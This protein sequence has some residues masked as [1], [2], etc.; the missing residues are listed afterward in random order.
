MLRWSGL[1]TLT[2]TEYAL[3]VVNYLSTR[4][5]YSPAAFKFFVRPKNTLNNSKT[6]QMLSGKKEECNEREDKRWRGRSSYVSTLNYFCK[7]S[8]SSRHGA[9]FSTFFVIF[10]LSMTAAIPDQCTAATQYTDWFL[11]RYH[12]YWPSQL[13]FSPVDNSSIYLVVEPVQQSQHI[14]CLNALWSRQ[15]VRNSSRV[16][17]ILRLTR[18]YQYVVLLIFWYRY[19][20]ESTPLF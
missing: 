17:V 9:L 5:G 11:R 19:T 13:E 12:D 15:L 6:Y 1:G 14:I 8:T 4:S 20:V 10:F 7:I 2:L 16:R 18:M 3:D